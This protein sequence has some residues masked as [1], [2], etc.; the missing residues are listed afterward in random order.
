[1]LW[2]GRVSA[3]KGLDL[4]AAAYS[5]AALTQR[6]DVRLVRGRRR[7]L[8]R[9]SCSSHAGGYVPRLPLGRRALRHLRLGRR[10]RVPRPAD[11]FGQV[12]LEAAASGLPSVVSAGVASTR[13]STAARRHSRWHR[14]DA[15]GFAAAVETLLDDDRAAADGRRRAAASAD[16]QLAGHLRHWRLRD[17]YLST[18]RCRRDGRRRSGGSRPLPARPPRR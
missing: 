10:V 2:V 6:D 3:E 7:T 8:P 9:D 15:E 4:L 17:A 16:Q 1:M 5:S 12:V 11:T 18:G 13:S 14:G